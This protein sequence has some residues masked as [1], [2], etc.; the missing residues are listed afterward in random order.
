MKNNYFLFN[1][2]KLFDK[3]HLLIIELIELKNKYKHLY[4]E[5]LFINKELKERIKYLEKLQH[6]N[7]TNKY[8]QV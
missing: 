8:N 6:D 3:I 7:T 5:Q 4:T 1:L 2:M